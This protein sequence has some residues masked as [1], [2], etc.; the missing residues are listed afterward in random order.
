MNAERAGLV[1]ANASTTS[2]SLPT[3]ML[4]GRRTMI[5]HPVYYP[6]AER[7]GFEP[8]L[9]LPVNSLSRRAPSTTRATFPSYGAHFAPLL[10]MRLTIFWG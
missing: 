5:T 4:L 7:A 1:F 9:R 3:A 2:L 8:A 10:A 6:N